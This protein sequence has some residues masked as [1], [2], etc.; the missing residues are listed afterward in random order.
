MLSYPSGSG[1]ATG[2][3]TL[4]HHFSRV[5]GGAHLC[6]DLVVRLF[7]VYSHRQ[8]MLF[9][10]KV[11]LNLL[12]DGD[13]LV[14]SGAVLPKVC[15]LWKEYVVLLLLPYHSSVDQSFHDFAH[16]TG[17]ADRTPAVCVRPVRALLVD[18]YHVRFWP[19]LM[20]M[21]CLQAVIEDCQE[22]GL[23]FGAKVF[24]NIVGNFVRARR[25]LVL[26]GFHGFFKLLSLKRSVHILRGDLL[27]LG[28]FL[29]YHVL[30]A[31]CSLVS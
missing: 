6:P 20:D 5:S 28:G 12:G 26:Q 16:T 3:Y 2:T 1:R 29:F 9:V 27:H 11:I 24:Q 4:L 10:R 14:S 23:C 18:R 25:L 17:E 30:A 19:A 22:F 8:R 31:S 13:H 15:L 7:H 21:P